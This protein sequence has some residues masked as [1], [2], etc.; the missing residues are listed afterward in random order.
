MRQ[1]L[2]QLYSRDAKTS[3]SAREQLMFHRTSTEEDA[4]AIV[5]ALSR[6]APSPRSAYDRPEGVLLGLIQSPGSQEAMEY[7]RDHAPAAIMAAWPR[8]AER[9]RGFALKVLAM[10]GSREGL[11]FVARTLAEPKGPSDYMVSFA[12]EAIP[13][14][15]EHVEALFPTLEPVLDF[16]D[17]RA[18][19][20]LDFANRLAM[21][22]RLRPHP[23]ATR[24]DRLQR[25]IESEDEGRYG[26]AISAC[27][28]LAS[29]PGARALELLEIASQHPDPLVR[30]EALY[31]KV[32]HGA[33][34]AAEAL[35]KATLDPTIALQARKYLKELGKAHLI[36][37]E[38]NDRAFLAKAEMISWLTHPNEFDGPPESI[39]LW[40]RRVLD[41]PPTKD[42]RE[43]FLF[44]YRYPAWNPEEEPEQGV[45][46]VGSV[47]FSLT[48]QTQPPPEG[49]PEDAY[50]A[51]CLWELRQEG[52]P[53]GETLTPEATRRL[54]G[55]KPKLVS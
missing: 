16:E 48:N 39:V 36:P 29:I 33:P 7:F 17:D 25:V 3:D 20:V 19:M 8:L 26:H 27:Y 10:I 24:L 22:G 6:E 54:L 44:H 28:A 18:V 12:L 15:T 49:T 11:A 46:L 30:M 50:V 9:D 31:S 37:K 45:G 53:R 55:F 4:R 32:R 5:E 35:A 40:D 41:W 42:R 1:L 51:H 14:D 43:L 13:A 23:A 2:D 21:A 47:T 52:D 34:D 38:A